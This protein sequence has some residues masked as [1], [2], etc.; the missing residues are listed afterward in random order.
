MDLHRSSIPFASVVRGNVE[1]HGW[2]YKWSSSG[3]IRTWKRRYAVIK[4]N[5]IFYFKNVKDDEPVAGVINLDD[6][7]AVWHESNN[8]QSRHCFRL[9]ARREPVSKAAGIL[10]RNKDIQFYVDDVE[11]MRNWMNA[12]QR[13]LPR[14]ESNILDSVLSRLDYDKYLRSRNSSDL[15]SQSSCD[16]MASSNGAPPLSANSSSSSEETPADRTSI[17]SGSIGCPGLSP[18]SSISEDTRLSGPGERRRV[19]RATVNAAGT[20]ELSHRRSSPIISNSSTQGRRQPG[21]HLGEL[22]MP[23]FKSTPSLTTPT[24]GVKV[25][26]PSS[27]STEDFPSFVLMMQNHQSS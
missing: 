2:L 25:P 9:A 6:Y 13:H 26:I 7:Y 10:Q 19:R 4:G 15:R 20:R 12:I 5:H 1:K 14:N 24:F 21:F 18:S 16:S 22:P 23:D 3:L 11:E 8:K 17:R 27:P